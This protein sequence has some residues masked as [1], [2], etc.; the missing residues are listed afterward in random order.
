MVGSIETKEKGLKSNALAVL[1]PQ[2]TAIHWQALSIIDAGIQM[3]DVAP[4]LELNGN[5]PVTFFTFTLQNNRFLKRWIILC[6]LKI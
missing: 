2:L 4:S 5:M 3:A 6:V 1:S